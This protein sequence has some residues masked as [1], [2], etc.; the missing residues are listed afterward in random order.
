VAARTKQPDHAHRATVAPGGD[1]L[2]GR[3]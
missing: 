2:G 3:W 1:I